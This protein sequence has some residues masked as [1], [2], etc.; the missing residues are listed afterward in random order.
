MGQ[1][2]SRIG[3]TIGVEIG[4][5]SLASD[6]P[7]R[8]ENILE[9]TGGLAVAF[10]GG[11]DSTFL[12]A[13]AA[14]VLGERALAITVLSPIHPERE[15]KGA[16][17]LAASIGIRQAVTEAHQ[18]AHP[19]FTANPPD[20]CYHCK[21]LIFGHMRDLAGQHG[22]AAVSG[23]NASD[24]GDYRPGLQAE[25]TI[26]IRRP[27]LDAGLTKADIRA[28][29]RAMDLPCAEAPSMACLASRVPYGQ[30]ITTEILARIDRCEQALR[31]MG[32][33]QL[34]VRDHDTL[35]RV[36]VPPAEIPLAIERRGEIVAIL[37]QAGYAYA[38]LDMKGYRTGAM[39]EVL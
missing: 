18:M 15:Q 24:T 29:A 3:I 7:G 16:A 13:V 25:T 38:T 5:N 28:I 19:E 8:L 1:G 32:F 10:S 31:A 27:L 11:C 21:T 12:A 22:F 34:R 36:E 2:K 33:S 30:A 6:R 26:G 14:Q 35:A 39:N 23:T 17:S 4:E 9:E 20:R 37:T